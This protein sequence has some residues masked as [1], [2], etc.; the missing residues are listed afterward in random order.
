MDLNSIRDEIDAIDDK[1]AELFEKRMELAKQVGE[2]KKQ[3]GVGIENSSREKQ[4]IA[5]VT[6]KMQPQFKLYAKRV[7]ETMFE[8]SKAYQNQIV[9]LHSKM[10]TNIENTLKTGV[11]EFPIEAVVACQGVDGA[12]S[13]IAC[14]KF[15]PI[16]SIS[17]FKD[18]EGVFKAVEQGFCDFGVLPIENSSAGS[19]DSV[20]DLMRKHKFF[21]VRSLKLKIQHCLLAKHG[22]AKSEIKEIFSHEQAIAQCDEF[23]KTFENVKI[24]VVANTA[25]GAKMVAESNRKD[26][27]CLSSFECAGI[28]GLNVVE[29]NVQDN[30]NNF[31]RFI[32]IS[33][34]LE[35]YEKSN[36]IS[37]MVNLPHET[38]S[39]N[40]ML[41]KFS[42][43]G[44]NLTK[45][46]SRPMPNSAFEFMF[47]F[48]FEADIEEKSVQNLIAELDNNSAEFVFLGS[49]RE[50]R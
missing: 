12:Y 28:Y 17:F 25:V 22:V 35:I 1:M 48:D 20:Y 16:S 13:S 15:F 45:L 37:I 36:K 38:G 10:Q 21:V 5:R 14:S 7:F 47:Y 32:V 27:A 39:L 43:L 26:V 24:T 9:E 50:L 29:Q 44:L 30:E 49:Y 33:K 40:K 3:N 4:I 6:S 8:T 18:F 34:N 31:T 23:L 19:V 42:S 46:E 11:K 41:N 2:F